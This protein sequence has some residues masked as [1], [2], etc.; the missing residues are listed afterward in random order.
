MICMNLYTLYIYILYIVAVAKIKKVS[1]RELLIYIYM[2]IKFC[3]NFPTKMKKKTYN[4]S[5]IFL[6]E[7]NIIFIS[8]LFF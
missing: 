5:I 8:K 3:K 4:I 2:M 1:V 7:K 6:Y